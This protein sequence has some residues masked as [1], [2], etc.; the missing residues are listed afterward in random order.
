MLF[1][2][3]SVFSDQLYHFSFLTWANSATYNSFTTS[4]HINKVLPEVGEQGIIQRLAV[5]YQGH[6]VGSANHIAGSK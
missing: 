5:Q 3:L 6:I 1:I 4:T 2:H